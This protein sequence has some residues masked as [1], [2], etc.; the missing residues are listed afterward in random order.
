M[1][2]VRRTRFR[3]SIDLRETKSGNSP[4]AVEAS[5][6]D[7]AL[8]ARFVHPTW[9]SAL[10]RASKIKLSWWAQIVQPDGRSARERADPRYS[11]AALLLPPFSFIFSVIP[12][13]RSMGFRSSGRASFHARSNRSSDCLLVMPT[14]KLTGAVLCLGQ[15]LLMSIISSLLVRIALA[16]PIPL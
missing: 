4:A 13:V 1:A 3:P 14:F 10:A 9:A 8:A 5:A 7:S 15:P 12:V 2:V 11:S 6:W 16:S